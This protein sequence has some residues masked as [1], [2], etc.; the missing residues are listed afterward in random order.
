MISANTKQILKIM[1][2]TGVLRPRDLDSYDI[3]RNYLYLLKEE[4]IIES[5]ERGI[6]TLTNG[7]F[8]L[9]HSYAEV[10]KKAPNAAICLL[11][12]LRFHGLTTTNPHE[13]WVAVEQKARA[14]KVG[15]PPVRVVWYSGDA[16]KEG[17]KE[18]IIEGVPVQIYSV[19][20]T[21]ADCFKYRHKIGLDLALEALREAWQNKCCT[22]S[23]LYQMAKVCRVAKVMQ[24]YLE[25][26]V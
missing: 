3:P 12:A 20:K 21:V 22:M 13:V 10:A 1:K 2:K 19:S 14:P 7:K 6:Y 17:R 26:L 4:G 15:N 9:F 23:E 18:H 8:T 16:F 11:S 5:S 24:P 25:S